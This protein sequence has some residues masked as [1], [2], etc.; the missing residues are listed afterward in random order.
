[1]FVKK[2]YVSEIV[3]PRR[4]G[5]PIVGWKDR[6]K[7]YM[8]ERV[9]N[10]GE[11]IE[12]ARK[13]CVDRERWKLFC[14]GHSLERKKHQII[15]RIDKIKSSCH[16]HSSFHQDVVFKSGYFIYY[17]FYTATFIQLN[18]LVIDVPYINQLHI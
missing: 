18:F 1:M 3:G 5:R 7:K 16:G 4:R 15:D 13:E 17:Y 11:G 9:V 6:V 8:H 14:R 12:L 2:V 10:R